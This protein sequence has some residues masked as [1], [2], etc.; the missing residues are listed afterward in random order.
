M[1]MGEPPLVGVGL[2]GD[3]VRRGVRTVRVARGH[4]ALGSPYQLTRGLRYFHPGAADEE[5][6]AACDA[7]DELLELTD[8]GATGGREEVAAIG[9]VHG[10]AG[11][12]GG[13]DWEKARGELGR[14]RRL[15][16]AGPLRLDCMCLPKRCHAQSIARRVSRP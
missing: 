13:W 10:F 7:Y 11:A 8:E 12:V 9:R 1:E 2:V 4:S 16:A 14:L 15:A 3:P 5:R 6:D